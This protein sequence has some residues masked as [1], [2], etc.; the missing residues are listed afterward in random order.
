MSLDDLISVIVPARNMSCFI[1]RTLQ[2]VLRQTHGDIEVIAVDDGSTDETAAIVTAIARQDERVR[3]LRTEPIG[4]SAA[5]NLAVSQCRGGLIAPMDADD[6]WHPRK[7]ERQLAVMRSSDPKVGVVYCWT[8]G[9]DEDDR[10]VLPQWI[11]SMATGNVLHELI[12]RGIVG[13]G[14]TPLIRRT[15]IDAVGGYDENLTLC[16]DW[17][18]Y[19]ALAG[20]CEFAV[21]PQ[22]LTAYRLRKGS[23]SVV[24]VTDMEA[25]IDEVTQW[26]LQSWPDIPRWVLLER[27]YVVASYLSF[28]ATRQRKFLL[29]LKFLRQS[30]K[31]KPDRLCSLAT[32][33]VL[34]MLCTHAAGIRVY[35]WDFWNKPHISTLFTSAKG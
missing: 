28:L 14:S 24:S 4:V 19:T 26:I 30:I 22:H 5:R 16:E 1:D 10:I 20:V 3:L 25:A 35:R 7:L 15:F 9:I 21:I 13:N 18:F 11:D 32:L 2:S 33:E 31:M 8:V 29:A 34:A 17:K 23:A 12:V 27:K 6:L